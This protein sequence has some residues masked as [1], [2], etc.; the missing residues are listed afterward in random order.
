MVKQI[1]LTVV[2]ACCATAQ[3]QIYKW[4]DENG[5]VQYTAVPPAKGSYE[6]IN[7]PPPASQ[8]PDIAM[9]ELKDKVSAVDKTREDAQQQDKA[10][11]ATENEASQRAANCE[12]AK[13]NLQ[14]L[15]SDKLVYKTDAQGNKTLLEGPQ[16]EQ[17][18]NQAR[19]DVDYFCAP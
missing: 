19:K 9:K 1:L 18:F 13:T 11:K 10:A 5:T 7:K 3:A 6:V 12:R 4:S 16:R 17:A 2:L 15:E 14:T 8:D